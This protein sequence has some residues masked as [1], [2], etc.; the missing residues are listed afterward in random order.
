MLSVPDFK[1]ASLFHSLI[2]SSACLKSFILSL[3]YMEFL[4]VIVARFY[5]MLLLSTTIITQVFSLLI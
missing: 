4:L 2:Q 5:Q 3:T 1:M